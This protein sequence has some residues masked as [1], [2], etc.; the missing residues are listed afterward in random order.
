MSSL[1]TYLQSVQLGGN[2]AFDYSK[3]LVLFVGLIVVLKIVQVVILSRLR[4]LAKKTRTDFD[5][6]LIEIFTKVRPPFYVLVSLYFAI[7]ALEIP[8]F[9][10]SVI[11]VAFVLVIVYEVV[12]ALSRLA[13]FFI[14]KYMAA[15]EEN[16]DEHSRTMA[17]AASIVL[18]V[19]LWVL[20]IAV[21]LS[22][23]GVDVTSL[24]A[25]LGIGGIAVALA[26]QNVL[27]DIFSSFS[28]YIDKPFKVG[29]FIVVGADK[30]TVEK[31]GLKS[32][33]IRS[34]QG[35]M[36]VV[37]N[38]ELTTARIQNF[39]QMQRRRYS[40][41]LGV[42]YGT[43]TDRLK[44]VPEMLKEI[45]AKND[46]T[47]VDRCHFSGFG[48]SSLDFEIVFY[49]N[50]ADYPVFMDIMQKINL[51]IYS[52]FAAEGIEF[53]FPTRTVHLER[54]GAG[55]AGTDVSSR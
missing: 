35:E 53:A 20:G 34:L 45:I 19:L 27:A 22:N 37:S 11:K 26:L 51:D 4:K 39:E 32:T 12:R 13:D 5:D 16:G 1:V 40:F 29:D 49:V 46:L 28:I 36:L 33:R 48:D 52:R 43:P 18:K 55:R 17:N 2:T 3:S 25:S 44:A 41:T 9:A 14:G 31:I 24:I 42:T 38:R 30:G 7:A 6:V 47:E 8:G 21:A 50:S 23:L 15:A 54:E 10:E